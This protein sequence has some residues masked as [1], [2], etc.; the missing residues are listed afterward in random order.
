MIDRRI[1]RQP[2]DRAFDVFTP[3]A[4]EDRFAESGRSADEAG[5]A[6]EGP[7][8][9]RVQFGSKEPTGRGRGPVQER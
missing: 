1:E 4:D 2:G 5:R 9:D 3:L 6:L 7:V 8:E